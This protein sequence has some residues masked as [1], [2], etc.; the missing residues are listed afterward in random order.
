MKERNDSVLGTDGLPIRNARFEELDEV[1]QLLRDAY[2]EYQDFV[3]A[4]VWEEYLQDIMNVRSRLGEAELLVA[5]LNGRLVG[6]VTL[7]MDASRSIQEGWPPGWA[8]IRLLA[9]Q[10]AYRGQGIGRALI[11][12]CFRRVREWGITT[13]GLHTTKFMSIAHRMYKR[14]GFKRAPEFDFHPAPGTV[15]MAYRLDLS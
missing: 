4:E 14:M 11:E 5:D 12:E 8:G 2:Q 15:V 9:V 13:I 1:S 3:P 7:Y 10:P 6:T